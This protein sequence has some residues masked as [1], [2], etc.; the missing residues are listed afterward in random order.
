[1]IKKISYTGKYLKP[2][3][4]KSLFEKGKVKHVDKT[5]CGNGFSTSFLTLK[6]SKGKRNII[7]APNKAVVIS[8]EEAYKKGELGTENKIKFFYQES[9]SK[10]GFEDADI[11]FFVA[12][13]FV[14]M[15]HKLK[16]INRHID[17]V[18]LDEY[19]S[20]QIQSSF[21][22]NLVNFIDQVKDICSNKTTSIVTVTAS[23][24][25]FAEVDVRLVPDFV[26]RVDIVME[27]DQAKTINRI[28]EDLA[29]EVNVVVCT[30][31]SRNIYLLRD[32][33]NTVSARFIMGTTLSR[34][35]Y[36][37]VKV[38][39][40]EDSNL[41]V[42]SARGFEGFDINYEDAH[43]YFLEDRSQGYQ[44]FY[45][46]NL[47]QAISRTRKGASYIE[48]CR[49][50][51]SYRRP[52][53]F[54]N[55]DRAVG[56]FIN[57]SSISAENKL[58]KKYQH[59]HPFVTWSENDRGEFALKKNKAA[60]DLSHEKFLYDYFPEDSAFDEF[61][62]N[63]NLS[64]GLCQGNQNRLSPRVSETV[65]IKNL[66]DNAKA[67]KKSGVYDESYRLNPEETIS[68][69]TVKPLQDQYLKYFKTFIRRKNYDQEYILSK[70][71]QTALRVLGDKTEFKDL[72]RLLVKTYNQRSIAKYGKKYSLGYRES[73][74]ETSERRLCRL[75][76]LFARTF[77]TSPPKWVAHRDYNILT[78]IG[79]QE[80]QLIA[81]YF[82]LRTLEVDAKS[83]FLR[84]LYGLCGLELEENLYGDNKENKVS[85]NVALN[86]VFYKPRSG[87]SKKLQRQN[88][89]RSLE[90]FGIDPLVVEY[91]ISNFFESKFR[92]DLFTH[93]SY[94]E[95]KLISSIRDLIRDTG[96]NN[97]FVRRHDSIMVFDNTTL[98]DFLND[99]KYLDVKGWFD[100]EKT[101]SVMYQYEEGV[102]LVEKVDFFE[103]L[104][105]E[106]K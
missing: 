84:I 65:K 47:Y 49:Q 97:G 101:R 57:R 98:L 11:L 22:D 89:R 82:G 80:I 72:L 37:L 8:K 77:I 34:G 66:L 53:P 33:K 95:K 6:P 105:S 46:S 60:I 13:S 73:F 68:A 91:L 75:I 87:T 2:A 99:T 104:E 25:L 48:Y 9:D 81:G 14:L 29:N 5:L 103:K 45:L 44:T 4:I 100:V 88:R 15:E 63:R 62:K 18:L 92:G 90:R 10:E 58:K 16:G 51:L 41:T 106:K 42:V 83:C 43:V 3:L 30:N 39:H 31:A 17:K 64:I 52:M 61:C 26:P 27:Y 1:M 56:K 69:S 19:H 71:Q 94:H 59:Y 21:R 35:L 78:E 85:L 40:D 24:N 70:R 50:D 102:Q 96:R 7:I 32:D 55:I 79:V 67:I 23:P 20:T 12:D 86:D 54:K 74:K 28:C 76:L 93:V 36:E 38:N